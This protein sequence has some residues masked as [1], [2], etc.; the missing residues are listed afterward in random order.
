M[1]WSVCY[2]RLGSRVAYHRAK[3]RGGLVAVNT[4]NQN[5]DKG[6]RFAKGSG[7]KVGRDTGE[8]ECKPRPRTRDHWV[9]KTRRSG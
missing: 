3:G 8:L 1:Q 9:T 7:R 6:G 2:A 4:G 5:E